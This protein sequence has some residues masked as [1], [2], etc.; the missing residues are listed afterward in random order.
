MVVTYFMLLLQHLS[1][2]THN[3]NAANFVFKIFIKICQRL[4]I[5]D[6]SKKT[7]KHCRRRSTYL[8]VTGL[9]NEDR[10]FSLLLT[11]S[12]LTNKCR[13]HHRIIYEMTTRN[14]MS[15]PH[16]NSVLGIIWRFHID[17]RLIPIFNITHTHTHTHT[18]IY[19]LVGIYIYIPTNPTYIH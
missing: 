11:N 2:W 1:A 9:C 19:I 3:N 17:W 15:P 16:R 12:G 10:V 18:Y 5:F 13:Y 8:Y 14:E 7:N 6:N 4:P